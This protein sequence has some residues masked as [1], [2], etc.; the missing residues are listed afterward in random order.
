M[1]GASMG[2]MISLMPGVGRPVARRAADA[3]SS[4]RTTAPKLV[5]IFCPLMTQSSP[6]RSAEVVQRRPGRL[7]AF[8]SDMPMHHVVSPDEDPGQELGL[9][10]G[11]PVG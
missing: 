9:L 10:V 3:G 4:S 1:P 8:G 6:S 7:P 5:Q 11:A 2:T